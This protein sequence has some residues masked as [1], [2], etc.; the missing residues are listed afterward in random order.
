[1]N[2]MTRPFAGTG[3]LP[4]Q[5]RFRSELMAEPIDDGGRR[6]ID[7]LD[8]ASGNGFRFYE[9]EY[10]LAC[11]MDGVRDIDGI[12]QWAASELGLSTNA[13]EVADVIYTLG[14]LG[15][16]D[17]SEQQ[18]AQGVVAAR[19]AR[20]STPPKDVELGRSGSQS[21]PPYASAPQPSPP[22]LANFDLGAAG[23]TAA[24]P[25]ATARGEDLPLGPAGA[26]GRAHAPSEPPMRT[27]PMAAAP[28]MSVAP[29]AAVPGR[30]KPASPPPAM[31][32]AIE[33]VP[34]TTPQWNP[35]PDYGQQDAS[36][37]A[38]RALPLPPPPAMEPASAYQDPGPARLPPR[39]AAQPTAT[40]GTGAQ[41]AQAAHTAQG[42]GGL[43]LLLV[44]LI[45][46]GGGFLLW[47]FVIN[48]PKPEPEPVVVA[49]P[50]A[51]PQPPKPVI[52]EATLTDATKPTAV[53]SVG[54]AGVISFAVENGSVVKVGDAVAKI[55]SPALDKASQA[56]TRIE[57]DLAKKW[58][59]AFDRA[60]EGVEAAKAGGK[61]EELAAAE[62]KLA[63]VAAKL[64]E[65]KKDLAAAKTEVS[66]W[67]LASPADGTVKFSV[68]AGAKVVA[69]DKVFEVDWHPNFRADFNAPGH[70]VGLG[71]HELK[72]K[73]G[74]TVNCTVTAVDGPKVTVECPGSSG[75]RNAMQVILPL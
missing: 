61:A 6:F 31:A 21:S 68:E 58:Q 23:P 9:A 19:T 24:P 51:P 16:L 27:Q 73:D 34:I 2:P 36:G 55:G 28:P 57:A 52:P 33:P 39:P 72:G 53:V 26:I 44:L 38:G 43:K 59:P 62:A 56:V 8:P 29:T 41:A 63:A 22:L 40:G 14:G 10:A 25:P 54:V 32:A 1:M 12:V 69:D 46:G 48:K 60:A 66:R 11:G 65:K 15:Y 50:V 45:L 75:A 74:S 49:P 5:P 42:G 35:Q 67:A 47:K 70:N 3:N 20:P 64:A 71:P 13:N 7:V 17:A 37:L 4:T 18:L 30:N